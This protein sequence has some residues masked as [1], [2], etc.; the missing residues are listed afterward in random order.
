M[1]L[2]EVQLDKFLLSGLIENG[3]LKENHM[4]TFFQIGM[5]LDHDYHREV[6]NYLQKSISDISKLNPKILSCYYKA[7]LGGMYTRYYWYCNAPVTS[8]ELSKIYPGHP[9]LLIGEPKC[10]CPISL[11]ESNKSV[12]QFINQEEVKKYARLWN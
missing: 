6:F 1:A 4:E 2:I 7:E 3:E 9:L 5:L 12:Y 10:A 11:N 8:Q